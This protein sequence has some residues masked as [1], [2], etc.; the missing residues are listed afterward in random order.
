MFRLDASPTEHR[1]PRRRVPRLGEEMNRWPTKQPN[2]VSY[3]KPVT[4]NPREKEA[5]KSLPAAG[6]AGRVEAIKF[7]V[8]QYM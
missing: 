7:T 5:Y 6:G 3:A 1:L 8:E 4:G 2:R